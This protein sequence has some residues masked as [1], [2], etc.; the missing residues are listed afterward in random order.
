MDDE[1]HESYDQSEDS[2]LESAD[3]SGSTP[4]APRPK[5]TTN[6]KPKFAD[7]PSSYEALKEELKGEA[8]G[9]DEGDNTQ[10]PPTTPGAQSRLPAMSMTPTSPPFDPTSYLTSTALQPKPGE[11]QLLHRVLDKNYR[12]QATP[13]T[14]HKENKTPA[15]KSSWRD[16]TSPMSSPP[17]AAPQLHAE[18]FSS[19]IRQQWNR[20]SGPRTPGISVQTPVK[21]KAKET[22]PSP[23]KKDEI[24]WESD[25]DEDAEGVYR[26]LGMSPPKTIQFSL[27][28]SRLLQ[29][30]G[31]YFLFYETDQG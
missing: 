31:T 10:I 9:Q 4:R 2:L 7:Y 15:N 17:V 14:T 11:K 16:T 13:H 5:S 3:I 1:E 29:T 20:P 27:P 12:L 22:V 26:E 21:G 30:P 18:I 28:Q 24:S 8:R 25:S 23:V 19:P 6:G